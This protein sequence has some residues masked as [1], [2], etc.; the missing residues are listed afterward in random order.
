M[1][2]KCS[3]FAAPGCGSR[4]W[5][6]RR[7]SIRGYRTRLRIYFCPILQFILAVDDN[8]FSGLQ[9]GADANLGSFCNRLR[10]HA[11]RD[12][13][14][15]VGNKNKRALRPTLNRRCGDYGEALLAPHQ[16]TYIYKLVWKQKVVVVF[17][18]GLQLVCVGRW[19]NCIVNGKEFSRCEFIDSVR[20]VCFNGKLYTRADLFENVRK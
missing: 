9:S 3:F 7:W 12:G 10:H 11:N 14:I 6:T 1:V 19:V 18:Y 2:W 13:A 16:N 15:R 5:R 20:V 8:H 17:K 4:G